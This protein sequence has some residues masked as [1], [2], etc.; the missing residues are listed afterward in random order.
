MSVVGLVTF[1][2]NLALSGFV[3][4]QM[5]RISELPVYR[6]QESGVDRPYALSKRLG[7]AVVQELVGCYEAGATS[8]DLADRYGVS[9]TGLTNLLHAQGAAVRRRCGLSP[10]DVLS[11]ITSPSP[12]DRG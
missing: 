3:T 4:E 11:L 9:R 5:P 1:K 8:A 10:T 6:R 7:M 2:L 12:R